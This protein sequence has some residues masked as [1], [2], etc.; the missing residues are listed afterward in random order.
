MLIISLILLLHTEEPTSSNKIFTM[1]LM[2]KYSSIFKIVPNHSASNLSTSFKNSG[3]TDMHSFK[4]RYSRPMY[5]L[6]YCKPIVQG[7]P[8]KSLGKS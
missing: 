7:S 2:E 5:D 6:D 8:P 4:A 3:R 1:S